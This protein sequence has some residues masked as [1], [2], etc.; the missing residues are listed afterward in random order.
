MKTL[1]HTLIAL[2]ILF[3]NTESY[4]SVR[5]LDDYRNINSCSLIPVSPRNWDDAQTDVPLNLQFIKAEPAMVPVAEF[6]W[7]KPDE[8]VPSELLKNRVPVSAK[9]WDETAAEAPEELRFIKAKYALVPVPA[10]VWTDI[11]ISQEEFRERVEIKIKISPA[12]PLDPLQMQL[13]IG[14]VKIGI[15]SKNIFYFPVA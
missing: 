9:T 1:V 4:S 3:M 6:V 15:N 13:M 11:E 14:P 7:G 2:L 10:K 5:N 8:A 12:S